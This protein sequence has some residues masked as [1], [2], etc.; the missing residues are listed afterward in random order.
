MLFLYM[1]YEKRDCIVHFLNF[2]FKTHN[3]ESIAATD[4]NFGVMIL[5]SSCYTRK[6]FCTTPTSGLGRASTRVDRVRKLPFYAP[7]WQFTIQYTRLILMLDLWSRRPKLS[8]NQVGSLELLWPWNGDSLTAW[9]TESIRV[10]RVQKLPFY[11]P[12]WQFTIQYTRLILA[13][14]VGSVK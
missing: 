11:A 8:T 2:H 13:S 10:D 12:L 4:F 1:N 6:E 7:L 3:L 9:K 5:K 14:N